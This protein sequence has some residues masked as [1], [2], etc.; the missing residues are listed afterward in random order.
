MNPLEVHDDDLKK[1]EEGGLDITKVIAVA[2]LFLGVLIFAFRYAVP[3]AL[4]HFGVFG[5]FGA[6]ALTAFA[7]YFIARL[8]FRLLRKKPTP[9]PDQP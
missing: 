1:I 6:A 5:A 9:K 7:L 3:S 4:E 8:F 2:I